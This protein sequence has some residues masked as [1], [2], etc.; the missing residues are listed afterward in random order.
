VARQ[1]FSFNVHST[2]WSVT[3]MTVR[4]KAYLLYLVFSIN[5]AMVRGTTADPDGN[6]GAGGAD[7]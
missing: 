5:V 1:Q 4:G 2:T 6:V 7:A 3:L